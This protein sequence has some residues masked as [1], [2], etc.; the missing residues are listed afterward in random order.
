[1]AEINSTPYQRAVGSLMYTMLG[2]RPDLA[3]A[4]GVLS[5][6]SASPGT[7]HWAALQRVYKYLRGLSFLKLTFRG[8]KTSSLTPLGYVDADW[9][10]DINNRRSITGF[11]YLLADGAICWSSKKQHSTAL[12]STEV[13]YMAACNAT[14]EALW[15]QSFLQE[16]GYAQDPATTI[17]IDNQSAMALAK[18]PAFHDRSKHIA[19]RY[20]FICEK[21]ED[22]IIQL[23]YVPTNDQV[24]DIFTKGLSCEKHVCFIGRMGL[25]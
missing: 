14:K 2:T 24:A 8:N 17:L 7:E 6:H 22:G 1:M 4:V 10:A 19:I 11:V 23:E 5:Q 12:S 16:L 18:N 9:A 21:V 3:Y 20:H 15:L 13:E 25:F